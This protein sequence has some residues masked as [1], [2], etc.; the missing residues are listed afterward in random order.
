MSQHSE[1]SS[2]GAAES[3]SLGIIV[4][5]VDTSAR[6]ANRLNNF[7]SKRKAGLLLIGHDE[8]L[9][10][11]IAACGYVSFSADVSLTKSVHP[12]GEVRG[13]FT[14]LKSCQSVWC[15]PICSARISSARRD[16]LNGLL[17]WGRGEGHTVVMLTLT[18]RHDRRMKL[19]PFLD[20]LKSAYRMLRQSRGWRGLGL[21]GS[22]TA[23]EVTHGSNGWHPHLHILMV[24]PA[25]S[26]GLA[27]IERLRAEWL[28]S[29]GKVGLS[30]A[31]AAFQVQSAQAAGEYIGK[32]GAGEELALGI[33]K[34]GRSG[35]R[36][37]WQLLSDARDGDARASALWIEYALAFKGK[38]Q[39]QWSQ[40]LK[41]LAGIDDISD[42]DLPAPVVTS[43]RS[44]GGATHYWRLARRR[45]C[46]LVDAAETDADLDAAE[47]GATDAERWR[48]ELAA[49]SVIE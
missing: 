12:S 42:D 37:P 30:G 10:A 40:G 28:R 27:A 18:A 17:A 43:L 2:S 7:A 36:S 3:G 25:G 23:S 41:A 34:G 46:S 38:R 19:A 16:E 22:V 39:L 48:Q 45:R 8:K 35:S 21:V 6:K 9:G 31:A 11:R 32:F 20:S 49:S 24:L 4:K 15:C 13:G 33:V 26:G 47:F 1:F 14:G 44:W 29:L 5:C